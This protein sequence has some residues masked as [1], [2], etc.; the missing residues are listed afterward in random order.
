MSE[1]IEALGPI[2]I[3]GIG[4]VLTVLWATRPDEP[5]S[6]ERRVVWINP[7]THDSFVA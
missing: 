2:A 7:V 5:T 3:M 4:M 1:L 6:A